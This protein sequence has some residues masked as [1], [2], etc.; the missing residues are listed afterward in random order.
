MT[1]RPQNRET[2]GLVAG[3]GLWSLAFLLLYG[4]HGAFCGTGAASEGATRTVLIGTWV[5]VLAAEA[6]LIVWFARRL[7]SAT[8]AQRFVRLA[9]LILAVAAFGAT[10]WTGVPV[11]TLRIC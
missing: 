5:A 6:A 1:R 9:S 2:L 8:E 10:V 3:F 11:L 7:R 4:G